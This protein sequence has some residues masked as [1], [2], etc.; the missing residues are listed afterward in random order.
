MT[1]DCRFALIGCGRIS[2][3]HVDALSIKIAGARIVA[4]ADI[5]FERAQMLGNRL[6]V[7][8]FSSASELYRSVPTD[9]ACILTP[10]G[11]HHARTLEALDHSLHVVVEKPVALRLEQV[12]EMVRKARASDRVLWVALQNRYNPAMMKAKQAVDSGRLG[13]IVLGTVRVRWYRD[14]N[15]YDNDA[16]RGTWVQ[17]GGVA[18]QQAIHHIDALQYFMGDLES[19]QATL[20]T[21]LVDIEAE[22]VCVA[23]IRFSSGA[24]GIIEATTAARPRD[25]EASLSIL[26]ERGTI[27]LGG[28]ALNK[29]ETWEFVDPDLDDQDVS[30][31]YSQDV[32]NAYGFGHDVLYERVIMSIQDDGPIEISAEE[33]RKSLEILHAIYRSAELERHVTLSEKPVSARLGL[34]A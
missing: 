6:G 4:V 17:D 33:G 18:S 27:V 23:T 31:L 32:P 24:L 9:V 26:G 20:A 14:Q 7:P 1:N 12:D 3:R 10:S 15:Y 25:F 13:R 28:L 22:D 21:R 16:W 2:A 34:V 29:I 8:C 19:I 30:R 5:Q 11:D